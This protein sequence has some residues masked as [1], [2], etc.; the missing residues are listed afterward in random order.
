MGCFFQGTSCVLILTK[1]GWATFWSML[2][3]THLVIE[4]L[5]AKKYVHSTEAT[6]NLPHLVKRFERVY[7]LYFYTIPCFLSERSLSENASYGS[8]V[9]Q[10]SF[11][12][13]DFFI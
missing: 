10:L 4:S 2:S 1:M 3:Q 7:S 12:Q 9:V 8:L 13:T 6:R 11:S 5:K